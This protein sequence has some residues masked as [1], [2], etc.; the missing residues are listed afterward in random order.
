MYIYNQQKTLVSTICK[1]FL[2]ITIGNRNFSSILEKR[3][4]KAI[5]KIYANDKH[6]NALNLINSQKNENKKYNKT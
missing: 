6:M 3:F 5:E 4:V 1:E 2:Q